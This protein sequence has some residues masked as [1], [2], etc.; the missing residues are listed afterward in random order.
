MSEPGIHSRSKA[1][2][3]CAGCVFEVYECASAAGPFPAPGAT[4][5]PP[6]RSDSTAK[7]RRCSALDHGGLTRVFDVS[8]GELASR[9][10]LQTGVDCLPESNVALRREGPAKEFGSRSGSGLGEDVADVPLV[11]AFGQEQFRSDCP[12]G[13]RRPDQTGDFPLPCSSS[14]SW[15]RSRAVDPYHTTDP[16]PIADVR[17]GVVRHGRQGIATGCFGAPIPAS[18]ASGRSRLLPLC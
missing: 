4:H 14:T 7:P 13:F 17:S 18:S 6:C 10:H 12:V 2:E 11:G 3:G 9:L 8:G 5:L 1:T 16:C 15:P